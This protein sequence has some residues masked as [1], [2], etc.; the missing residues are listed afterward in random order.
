MSLPAPLEQQLDSPT[1]EQLN[2]DW[3]LLLGVG[4]IFRQI[5]N[6]QL[7]ANAPNFLLHAIRLSRA[8]FRQSYCVELQQLIRLTRPNKF[9][10]TYCLF[11]QE[12]SQ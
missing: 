6:I 12:H 3:L 10:L 9:Q 7:E 8:A 5:S 4:R 2:A 1:E 11:L